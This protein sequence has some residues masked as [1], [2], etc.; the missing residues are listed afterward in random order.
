MMPNGHAMIMRSMRGES[1]VGKAQLRPGTARRVLGFARPYRKQ[2][3]A[4]TIIISLDALIGVATPVLAGRVIN[5]IT[6]AGS[7]RVVVW[8]AIVIALLAILDAAFS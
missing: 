5:E 6:R 1:E 4:F 3:I 8:I 7:V 2:L